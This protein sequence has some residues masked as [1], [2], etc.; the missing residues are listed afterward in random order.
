[1]DVYNLIKKLE[2]A[3]AEP[4]FTPRVKIRLPRYAVRKPL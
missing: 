4:G 3:I 1:M 2:M